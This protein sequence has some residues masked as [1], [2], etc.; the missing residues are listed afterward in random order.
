MQN[1]LPNWSSIVEKTKN[2]KND[3][4]SDIN[5]AT[6]HKKNIMNTEANIV[7][8]TGD[9]NIALARE[10][11]SQLLDDSRVPIS[12]R[13]NL[14]AEYIQ[15]KS[16]LDKLE[17][18][19]IHIAVFGRV[20][21]GKSSV[22]NA[23]IGKT[24][25]S[26]SILHGETKTVDM[27]NWSEY[28]DGGVYLLD[29]PGINE[30]DGE[31]RE[32]M[33]HNVAERADLILFVVDSDLTDVEME[34]FKVV[35]ATNR[36]IILVVN[37][38]DQYNENEQ[39]QLR[40]IIRE[41]VKGL[42][43][44]EN[45][46]FTAASPAQQTVIIV[47]DQGNERETMRQ[48]PVDIVNLKSR[49]WD[50]VESE[51]KTLSA[52]NA[53]L[54]AGELSEDVS[55]AIIRAR[56]VIAE[57]TIKMYCI[58]KGVAVAVNP[59]PLA[60]LFAAAASDVGMM[61]HLSKIY[62]LPITKSEAGELIKTIAAQ[63]LLLYGSAWAV[64]VFSS[65]FKLGTG[66]ASTVITAAA[67]GA[68][69]Y[70]STLVIGKVAQTYFAQGKSWGDAGPK[71]VVQEILDNLDRGSVVSEAKEEIMLYLKKNKKK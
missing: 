31:D 50:I 24:V 66:G 10:S 23:L 49:L 63:M 11:L 2:A 14:K 18:G 5:N 45:I 26:T 29:T 30:I 48:R 52:L 69:A 53:T 37:K 1:Y 68:I 51:G 34:A 56:F 67:Q 47:D 4:D 40:K 9:K 60:D 15:V 57:K 65:L 43:T 33:A 41:R 44:P 62:G 46:V 28:H 22:L 38:A 39:L 17:N 3:N 20:S 19:H 7:E 25:F 70:Y 61:V 8:S 55:Q 6:K 42:I 13:N 32:A 35:T 59:I 71:F 12:I 27:Q 54:F 58:G 36:P 64:N 21:V 16:M